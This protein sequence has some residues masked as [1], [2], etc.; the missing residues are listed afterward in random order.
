VLG[1]GA[2]RWDRGE[3]H[4]RGEGCGARGGS[5]SSARRAALP[6]CGPP[7]AAPA[8]HLD[9]C[10]LAVV[11]ALRGRWFHEL[12]LVV[13]GRSSGARV[14]CRTAHLT[15]AAGV[16]LLSRSPFSRHKESGRRP[17]RAVSPSSTSWGPS[18]D[19]PGRE[20]PLRDASR[21]SAPHGLRRPGRPQPAPRPGGRRTARGGV[22]AAGGCPYC[23]GQEVGRHH[24]D[25]GQDIHRHR[26]RIRARAGHRDRA[27]RRGRARRLPRCRCRWRRGNG[28]RDR[29]QRRVHP[30]GRDLRGGGRRGGGVGGRVAG[31][32]GQLRGR[33]HRRAHRRT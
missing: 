28:G 16:S 5:R 2:G 9:T 4:R 24:G 12:P 15:R 23:C 18:A 6:G 30:R 8:P 33:R 21:G 22:A 32:R 3:R 11:E 14:A 29:R 7:L 13:G 17:G 31:G 25:R 19:R 1:H 26:R 27:R 20:R 10:W